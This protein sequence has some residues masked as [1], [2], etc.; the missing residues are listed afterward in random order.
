LTSRAP[1][2]EE[3]IAAPSIRAAANDL[4]MNETT[5]RRR[6]GRIG[7]HGRGSTSPVA[8]LLADAPKSIET[9]LSTIERSL[10]AILLFLAK[11]E[12]LIDRI[13]EHLGLKDEADDDP[14]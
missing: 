7:K 13:A 1:A 9:R 8:L 12:E 10:A 14:L 3:R 4:G 11:R 2:L 6:L 5:L